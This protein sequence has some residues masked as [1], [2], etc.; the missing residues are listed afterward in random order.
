MPDYNKIP[1]KIVEET[2]AIWEKYFS[3]E[4]GKRTLYPNDCP[5]FIKK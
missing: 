4:K 5:K 3:M 2:V 1:C